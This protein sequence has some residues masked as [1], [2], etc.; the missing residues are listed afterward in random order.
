MNSGEDISHQ[1]TSNSLSPHAILFLRRLSAGLGT[2]LVLFSLL[3]D[4]L[5]ISAAGF[6]TG[7]GLLAVIG[8]TLL[9]LGVLGARTVAIYQTLGVLFLNSILLVVMV[10]ILFGGIAWI[11][12]RN[13][14]AEE[15]NSLIDR[16]LVLPYYQAQ[17]WSE[18]YWNE[19]AMTQIMPFSPFVNTKARPFSGTY[20]NINEQG[21]RVV[22]ETHCQADSYTIFTFGGSTMFGIGSPDWGTIPVYLQSALNEATDQPICII[23]MGQLAHINDQLIV[24]LMFQL[25]AGHVPDLVLFYSGINDVHFPYKSGTLDTRHIFGDLEARFDP[26]PPSLPQQLTDTL[27]DHSYTYK[28]LSRFVA[29]EDEV[30]DYA[31]QE[32]AA[33]QA[34]H[35][36]VESFAQSI[37]DNIVWNYTTVSEWGQAYGF[38]VL[39]FWQPVLITGQKTLTPEE[40][41]F[42]TEYSPTLAQVYQAVYDRIAALALPDL[43]DISTAFDEYEGFIWIDRFHIVPE[44]NQVVAQ[45]MFPY[46]VEKMDLPE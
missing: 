32:D 24:E 22:P 36:E 35:L 12:S 34:N 4:P 45:A 14:T 2:G 23:N 31:A 17:P 43:H 7:Q 29:T 20:I 16:F 11:I 38:D 8:V 5:G 25:K 9:V 6:S 15:S 39:F 19:S 18:V 3:A 13:N 28:V 41:A 40:A 10:E 44:G 26:P 37:T 1:P 42:K 27:R 21:Q 30:V 46:I 33:F